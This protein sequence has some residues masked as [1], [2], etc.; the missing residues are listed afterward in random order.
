MR[1]RLP[2]ENDDRGEAVDLPDDFVYELPRSKDA[3]GGSRVGFMVDGFAYYTKNFS[4]PDSYKGKKILLNLDGAYMNTMIKFN[5]DNIAMHPYGYT[6]TTVDLTERIRF[7]IPNQLVI[8]THGTQPSSRWYSGGIYRSVDLW[9]GEPCYLDPRDLF[10]T[11]PVIEKEYASVQEVEF[12]IN[13][14]PVARVTPDELI[15]KATL[16]LSAR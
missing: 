4:L 9:T 2:W 3:V 15:F 5:D 1:E 10:I 6:P 16:H 8:T 14:K 13:G 7:D 12:R 11:T